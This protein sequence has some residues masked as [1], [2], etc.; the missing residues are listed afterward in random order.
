MAKIL[1]VTERLGDSGIVDTD[2]DYS[3]VN[4][5]INHFRNK[6][7]EILGEMLDEQ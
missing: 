6:S 3:I 2:I 4:E 7:I 1:G 5:K